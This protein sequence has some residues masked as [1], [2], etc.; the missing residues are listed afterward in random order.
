[1]V[2][3]E[4]DFLVHLSK[5]FG[6]RNEKMNSRVLKIYPREGN[7]GP[8]TQILLAEGNSTLVSGAYSFVGVA[9]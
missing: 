5:N 7:P 2:G 9:P 4:G 1:M 6:P 8:M 3:S